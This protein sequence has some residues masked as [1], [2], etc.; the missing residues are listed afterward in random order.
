MKL[1][2]LFQGDSIT[3]AFRKPEEI[4]PAFQ[5]G[6]GYAFLIA[7]RLAARYPE[8]NFEFAN[9][10]VCGQEVQHVA[11]RLQEDLPALRPDLVSLLVGVSNV[12]QRAK[13]VSQMTSPEI[14]EAYRALLD[15]LRKQDP[16]IKILLLEPFL[17]KVDTITSR[18]IDILKPI[19]TG[20]AR[21]ADDYALPLIPLQSTFDAALR[22]APAEYWAYDGIHPTHAGFQLIADAWIQHAETFL[23][24]F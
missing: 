23:N 6:N 21:I 9:H 18:H 14:L 2:I 7:A 11:A 19:Q 24:L 12:L 15:D 4:N 1:K 17:L 3:H 16:K 22:E 13:G 5:L 10:A 8:R 20:L